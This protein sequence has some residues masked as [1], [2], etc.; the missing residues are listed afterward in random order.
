MGGS[1]VFAEPF[2][3][4]PR[5]RGRLARMPTGRSPQGFVLTR[6]SFFAHDQGSLLVYVAHCGSITGKP[7]VIRFI[8]RI[9][10]DKRKQ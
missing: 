8:R 10:N 7:E 3:A 4:D 2:I 5:R 6:I 1:V 9:G